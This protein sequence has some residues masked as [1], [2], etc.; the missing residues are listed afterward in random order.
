[1]LTVFG[2]SNQPLAPRTV[3]APRG[4]DYRVKMYKAASQSAHD[5]IERAS[6]SLAERI[7]E[8]RERVRATREALLREGG[9]R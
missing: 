3:R 1:M 9:R 2:S 5:E 4:D 6:A 7:A 8:E